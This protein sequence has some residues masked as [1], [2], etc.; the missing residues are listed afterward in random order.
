M[1]D[2]QD[3]AGFDED[4]REIFESYLVESKE[5]LDHLSQD[6][7]A[8]EKNPV[9]ADLLNNI[10][11][12]VH[13]LKGTSSFL[14]F[15]QMTELTHISEDLLNKLR[16]GELIADG[17]IID[18]LIEAHNAASALL[19]R[20]ESRDLQPIELNG[21]LEKLQGAMKQQP[22]IAQVED[23]AQVKKEQALYAPKTFDVMQQRAAD[24]TIRVDIERLDDLMNLV[25]EL[26]LARNRL[27][28]ATQ[29]LLEKYERIEMS[30]SIADV[31]SQ[32]DF[33]TTELQMAVMKTRMVPIEKVFN[34]LPLLAR[35]LMRTTGK[36]VDLQIYG[37]ETELDKSIIEELNDP[38]VH[39]V[40]NAID[41]GIELPE[42]RIKHGK[43]PQGIVV[44]NAERDGN[45]IL[46]T[47]EDD[48]RGIDCEQ[49]KQKA[50]EK[51]LV[52]ELQT[53]EMSTSDI[54]NLIFI[55]GFSTKQ[56]A[57]NVSGRGVG[58]DVVKTNIAKLKGIVEIASEVGKGTII[59]LKVPLTLAIIQG[60]LMKVVDEIFAV[61]LSAVLEIIR[62]GPDEIY[63][64]QGR[65]VIRV[66]DVI[67]PLARM[68]D[69]IGNPKVIKQSPFSYVVV[70]GWAE[71]RIGLLVDSLQGQKEIVIKGLG[72]YLGDVPGIAGSTILGDGSVILV[73][74]V[75]Q[76]IELF[77]RHFG[78]V[79]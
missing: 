63:T 68:S 9:N 65:E 2:K 16:K 5:I 36:E 14:G 8:L 62:I 50:I 56:E 74:D 75:G 60:L 40:R 45:Y 3:I 49:I 78:K 37:K 30:K 42:E 27:S 33:V 67:L 46:I 51:G 12:G 72:N 39:M 26:V 58:M 13:T 59:T 4:M 70:V 73:I 10:F 17:K 34:G 71:K 41:H 61:P 28:Q 64:I 11:R 76:F 31:S 24:T 52:S 35:D 29:S 69:I 48:G 20:I 44:V 18:V 55:P 54:L 47:M 21:I 57:T 15:N 66:R 43:P 1:D 32:I 23:F 79:A 38:L 19:Q 77:A 7:I 22:V 53:R 6:L 25:G